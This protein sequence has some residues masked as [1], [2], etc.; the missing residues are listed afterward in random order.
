MMLQTEMS[1]LSANAK[2]KQKD[3]AH[4]KALDTNDE[5]QSQ[6]VAE[7]PSYLDTIQAS[8]STLTEADK[9]AI[10]FSLQR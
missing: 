2:S 4:D 5:P 9:E 3:M 7:S 1:G 10:H 8:L 6:W